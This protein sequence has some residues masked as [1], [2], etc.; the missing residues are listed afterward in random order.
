MFIP[1]VVCV[2]IAPPSWILRLRRLGTANWPHDDFCWP[3]TSLRVLHNI[4]SSVQ[5]RFVPVRHRCCEELHS[6]KHVPH[7]IIQYHVCTS[8]ARCVRS[9]RRGLDIILNQQSRNLY[10]LR[11]LMHH[12]Q[13]SPVRFSHRHVGSV[14]WIEWFI[15]WLTLTF[16]CWC[17]SLT[18]VYTFFL[19]FF[20]LWRSQCVPASILEQFQWATNLLW[21]KL[22]TTFCTV[23][24][25]NVCGCSCKLLFVWKSSSMSSI[26]NVIFQFIKSVILSKYN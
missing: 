23:F 6:R 19:L 8:S 22:T 4:T 3:C 12:R 2:P 5:N 10:R 7:T 11:M 17:H 9:I 18:I 14:C 25:Q 15:P 26:L 24:T 13:N 16:E 21:K 1:V 20:G